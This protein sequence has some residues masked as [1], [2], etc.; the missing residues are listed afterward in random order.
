MEKRAAPAPTDDKRPTNI[1]S[2]FAKGPAEPL[3]KGF[4]PRNAGRVM[5]SQ[6]QP[7]AV[8]QDNP[9]AMLGDEE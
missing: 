5:L 8:E 9:F 2:R 7:L 6:A 4:A 1:A 3:S